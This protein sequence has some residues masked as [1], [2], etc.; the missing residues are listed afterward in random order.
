MRKY[1]FFL[2]V[3]SVIVGLSCQSAPEPAPEPSPPPS[4][5]TGSTPNT[6]PAPAT[7]SGPQIEGEATQEKINEALGHIYDKYRDRLDMSGAQEYMVARGD[8]L[9]QITRQFYGSLTDV[10]QAGTTNG[11]YYP[12]LMVASP[13]SDIVDPD[14]IEP[15]MI[16]KIPDLK[17]N[18]VNPI[19]RQAI[20]DCL[21]D[22]SYIY[23]KKEKP[24][25]EEG[26]LRLANSL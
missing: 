15:G 20:K 26:L 1:L 5:A 21:V 4:S 10:G 9:S 7:A 2:V 14:L 6:T 13:E 18:L 17:K 16:L 19:A 24:E 3:I 12:L 23:N 22:V 25:E 8:T 11:F